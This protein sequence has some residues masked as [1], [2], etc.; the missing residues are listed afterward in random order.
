[1]RLTTFVF[2]LTLTL[3][4]SAAAQIGRDQLVVATRLTG[5]PATQLIRV[6]LNTQQQ[7][8]IGRFPSDDLAPLAIKLDP[9]ND[10]LIVALDAGSGTSRLIRLGLSGN[11]VRY[12]RILSDLPHRVE[13]ADQVTFV[14]DD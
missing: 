13:D 10:D 11:S 1:M 14:Y 8:P 2:A 12:E 7:I 6:D 3:T 9:I 4:T 5:T